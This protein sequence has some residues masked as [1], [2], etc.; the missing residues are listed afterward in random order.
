MAVYLMNHAREF[1]GRKL[2]EL[3]PTRLGRFLADHGCIK[4]HKAAGNAWRF[5][6]LGEAR[7]QWSAQ[8]FGYK[9]GRDVGQ[10]EAKN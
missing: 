6:A 10:W 2:H 9:F 7:A 5:P 1:G 8:Y 3:T 4:L